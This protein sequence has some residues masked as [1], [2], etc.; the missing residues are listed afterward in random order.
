MQTVEP[1]SEQESGIVAEFLSKC[2]HKMGAKEG[3]RVDPRIIPKRLDVNDTGHTTAYNTLV[4]TFERFAAAHLGLQNETPEILKHGS[5]KIAASYPG[6]RMVTQIR[7]LLADQKE[8]GNLHQSLGDFSNKQA[9][10][11]VSLSLKIASTPADSHE[12]PSLQERLEMKIEDIGN[13]LVKGRSFQPS[14][15]APVSRQQLIE[16]AEWSKEFNI[17]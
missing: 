6:L 7:N 4:Q 2:L 10:S 1:A 11:A 5:A 16:D 8:L 12:I 14:I 17:G 13:M 3:T 15:A 9:E